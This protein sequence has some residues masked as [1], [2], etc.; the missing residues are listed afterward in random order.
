MSFQHILCK[1]KE[2]NI[3]FKAES[4]AKLAF[5]SNRS[6]ELA[7]VHANIVTEASEELIKNYILARYHQLLES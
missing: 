4:A 2:T 6:P 1:K 3:V 7:C 5:G